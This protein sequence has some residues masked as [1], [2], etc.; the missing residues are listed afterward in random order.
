VALEASAGTGK[1]TVL[2]RRYVRLLESGA[3]PRHI[4]AITFTRKAAGE[5]RSK[6]IAEL[7]AN[8]TLWPEIRDRLLDLHVLTLDA[9]CL[10]L[11]KEFPLEAGVAPD[12][13]LL[14]E[15]EVRELMEEAIEE[16]WEEAAEAGA[17]DLVFLTGAVGEAGLKRSLQDLLRSRLVKAGPIE[18]ALARRLP[19]DLT[20][21]GIRQRAVQALRDATGGEARLVELLAC[22][23]GPE[24]AR[25]RALGHAFRRAIDP[26][27]ATVYDVEEVLSYFLTEEGRARQKLVFSK[28]DFASAGDFETHR[29][30]ALRLAPALSELNRRWEQDRNLYAVRELAKLYR[31]TARR[32][33]GLKEARGGLDFTDTLLRAVALLQQR[34]EFSQSRYRLEARYHHLLIDEFQDTNEAQWELVRALVASWGEGAG[35]VQEVIR[36][37]QAE[38]RGRGILEEPSLFIVGDR[39]QSI[40]GW[41]DAR[42]EVMERAARELVGL[43]PGGGRRLSIRRCFRASGAL[44]GFVNDVFAGVEKIG[45]A[46]DWAFRYEEADHFPAAEDGEG[47]LGL[48]VAED[49]RGAAAAVADEI[50]RLLQQERLE[51]RQ[52]AILFRSRTH[53]RAYE[54]ALV[55]RGVPAYVYRG[56]G[57]F[58]SPE[59][60]DIEAL[61]RYLAK[62]G[63]ELRA[64]ELLRSRFIHLSDT[65]LAQIVAARKGGLALL[66]QGRLRDDDLAALSQADRSAAQR[67][68]ARVPAWTR[69]A[70]QVPPYDLIFEILQSCDYPAWFSDREGPQ[71]WENLKKILELVRRA[72]NRGYLTFSRLADYLESAAAGEEA[73]AV[74]EAVDAVNLMTLHAAKGLE[75]EAVFVVNLNQKTRGE[76]TLPRIVETAGGEP[77]IHVLTRPATDSP[78]RALEE[79]KRLLYVALTRA[80]R[81]LV[82]SAYGIDRVETR[83]TLLQLLPQSLTALFAEAL[84]GREEERVWTPAGRSHRLTVLRPAPEPRFYRDPHQEP[85]FQAMLE[86]LADTSLPPLSVAELADDASGRGRGPWAVD[87]I[88]RAVGVAVHRLFEHAVAP[89]DAR[90]ETMDALLPERAGE[91]PAE[92]KNAA[93]RAAELYQELQREPRLRALLAR[94]EIH[95]EVPVTLRRQGALVRGVIDALILVEGKVVVVDYKTGVRAAEHVAQLEIYLEAVGRLFPKR[96]AEGWIF[97]PSGEPIRL[98]AGPTQLSFF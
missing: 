53:Y 35:L 10:G 67:A 49:L 93:Q 8:P 21:E 15:V 74:L 12:I 82:L 77:E 44:L 48:A 4:L 52:I 87:P 25:F 17:S 92:R 33:A 70:D 55:E 6:L 30:L 14:D 86:P 88:D 90:S 81:R 39:K 47:A 76:T 1:T 97:Y 79:E 40:Y 89:E 59:V 13:D 65:G 26:G 73:L 36:A 83:P 34:G 61:V 28:K 18:R 54:R 29:D 20:L 3:D 84:E 78:D 85:S 11:L 41:R 63:S 91:S 50:V 72:Q 69:R 75:F 96:A 66:L 37:E 57:F 95:R 71:G 98:A 9:F 42:V 46:Y 56:L 7:R 31:S 60:K 2:V 51:P 64:G 24:V 38:G 68:R 32:F 43:R 27:R 22:G 80:R 58:D 16:A 45:T 62:P 94:G 23:P 19:A 5:M